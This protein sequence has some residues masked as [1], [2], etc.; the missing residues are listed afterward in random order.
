MGPPTLKHAKT[1]YPV[2]TEA[3]QVLYF[4]LPLALQ[5]THLTSSYLHQHKTFIGVIQMHAPA[6]PAL[7]RTPS[8]H[9]RLE[10]LIIPWFSNASKSFVLSSV[11]NFRLVCLVCFT[12]PMS[13]INVY[14]LWSQW[15]TKRITRCSTGTQLQKSGALSGNLKASCASCPVHDDTDRWKI[16]EKVLCQLVSG[17]SFDFE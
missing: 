10:S 11:I 4:P 15:Y 1:I 17:V 12:F 7:D 16:E 13:K 14:P 5:L 8:A 2:N 9:S 3:V 6:P